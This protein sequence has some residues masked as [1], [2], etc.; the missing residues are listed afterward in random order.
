MESRYFRK[1][2]IAPYLF[3][4]PYFLIFLTFA[5]FPIFFSAF[6]SLNDW[7]G[8]DTPTFIGLK[9]YFE[10]FKDAR[11]FKALSN[12]L[13]L[14]A[15]IIPLQ[16][17]LGFIIAV[18]LSSKFM[19][20]KGTFRVLNFLPYLTTPIALGVIFA[21]LFDPAFGS[22]N[23]VLG[24]FGIKAIGWTKEVWPARVLVSFVTIWRWTGYT[25]V[26]FLAG[27]TNIN[28]D[29]YEASEIDGA[30]A[31]QRMFRITLPLLKPVMVFVII[32]TMIGC[33]QIFEEPFMIFSVAGRMVGGPSNSVLTGIWLFYDTAFSNQFRNGYAASIAI[34]LFAVIAAISMIVNRLMADKEEKK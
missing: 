20:L 34:C 16:I 29:I 31:L 32:T 30:N 19:A 24:L 33:F 15:M 14:M 28:T 18:M 7:K 4:L 2:K 1:Q 9:N 10:V 26:L 25:A 3:V 8:Y 11:F 13:L 22:V 12:T 21:L 23:Y 17:V 6:I 5:V 27:I